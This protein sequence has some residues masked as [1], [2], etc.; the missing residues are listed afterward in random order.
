MLSWLS[1]KKKDPSQQSKQNNTPT[2]VLKDNVGLTALSNA[3][4]SKVSDNVL[5]SEAV[6]MCKRA[7]NDAKTQYETAKENGTITEESVKS[8]WDNYKISILVGATIGKNHSAVKDL[9]FKLNADPNIKDSKTQMTPLLFELNTLLNLLSQC[10]TYDKAN[11]YI[12]IYIPMIKTLLDSGAD[13]H[14][15]NRDGINA[16]DYSDYVLGIY[17]LAKLMSKYKNNINEE[18]ANKSKY[19]NYINSL[20][21]LD[22]NN[23]VNKNGELMRNIEAE[24]G[25]DTYK[26]GPKRYKLLVDEKRYSKHMDNI[27][28][29]EEKSA[30]QVAAWMNEQRKKTDALANNLGGGTR[31]KHRGRKA[32]KSRRHRHR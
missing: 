22:K 29:I 11:N 28:K 15:S 32:K 18:F 3:F 23:I 12:K 20:E 14:I 31:R 9:I 13:P 30:Q 17:Q 24:V 8:C 26:S 2:K 19:E 21:P 4:N 1:G 16:F 25:L 5:N 6:S 10:E 27:G 7:M